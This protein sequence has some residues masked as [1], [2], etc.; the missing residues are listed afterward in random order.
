MDP[1]LAQ[2]P[3][4]ALR[5]FEASARH[6]SFTRAAA[7][8]NVTQSAVSHQVRGLELRLGYELFER[9]TRALALTPEGIRLADAVGRGLAVIGAELAALDGERQDRPVRITSSSSISAKWL[10]AALGR[11]TREH[12]SI[13]VSLAAEDRLLDPA[14]DGID[15]ALRF[16]PTDASPPGRL[17]GLDTLFPVCR[18]GSAPDG[19][20]GELP[21]IE[22]ETSAGHASGA[23]WKS[24][25]AA[26]GSAPRPITGPRVSHTHLA[27]QAA[28]DG[29]GVAMARGVLAVEDLASGRL[30]RLDDRVVPTRFGYRLLPV[31]PR[32]AKARLVADWIAGQLAPLLIPG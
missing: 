3:W 13:A 30:E 25:F 2:I 31:R 9:R 1:L 21:L 22:D 32:E 28:A 18:P 19:Q 15:L 6:L 7:E 24:W 26:T 8:L 20:W 29:L 12:P 23:D 4:H 17:L 10:M 11:F 14:S 16:G 5:V 27:M